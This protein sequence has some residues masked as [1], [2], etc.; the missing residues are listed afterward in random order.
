MREGFSALDPRQQGLVQARAARYNFPQTRLVRDTLEYSEMGKD[1][2]T[3]YAATERGDISPDDYARY[4]YSS[5]GMAPRPGVMAEEALKSGLRREEED[6]R[7]ENREALEVKRQTNRMAIERFRQSKKAGDLPKKADI[8]SEIMAGNPPMTTKTDDDGVTKVLP[9]D[10][11]PPEFIPRDLAT[12]MAVKMVNILGM[13]AD[14]P[15]EFVS[16]YAEDLS[17]DGVREQYLLAL[18][19][20]KGDKAKARALVNL[21]YDSLREL[22]EAAKKK[23]KQR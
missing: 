6:L 5:R 20:A 17:A 3:M 18:E 13:S 22:A 4:L 8:V 15:D 10:M 7:Q 12:G 14:L 21:H 23:S 2:A 1:N 19:A 16:M 11:Q 9:P